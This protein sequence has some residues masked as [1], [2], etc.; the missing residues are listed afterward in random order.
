[1]GE[2]VRRYRSPS[3]GFASRNF[4]ASF[5]AASRIDREPSRYFGSIT[6]ESPN[7]YTEIELPW[8]TPAPTLAR[9]LGIDLGVLQEHNP[10]LRPAVWNGSKHIPRAYPL[11][12]PT[13][14]LSR[15]VDELIAAVPASARLAEQHRDRFHK[16]R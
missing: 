11:R 3:F 13:S 14:S 7:V 5:L 6:L 10:A 16:V 15:P 1:M 4:Y 12:L 8:F 2:I 9:T